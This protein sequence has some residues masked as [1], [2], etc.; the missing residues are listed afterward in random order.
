MI[1]AATWS[2]DISESLA[3]VPRLLGTNGARSSERVHRVTEPAVFRQLVA[4]FG[5]HLRQE[6]ASVDLQSLY[7]VGWHW[8]S[9]SLV[10]ASRGATLFCLS[11]RRRQA[12]C[13]FHRGLAI[14]RPGLGVEMVNVGLVGDVYAGPVA[15]RAESACSPSFLYG[16]QRC[17]CYAQWECVQELAAHFNPVSPPP[18]R[19]GTAF[20]RWVQGQTTV[21][22]DRV[23]FATPGPLGFVLMHLD[24]QNGMGSGYTPG[25]FAEDLYSCASMRHRGEYSCEQVAGTSMAGAFTAIGLE[26]DPRRLGDGIGYQTA[27]I[28][29]DFLGINQELVFLGNNRLK[30]EHELAAP[31]TIH[32]MPLIGT[33][34]VAGAE[35]AEARRHEFAHDDI[36]PLVSFEEDYAR[37]VSDLGRWQ[38][39]N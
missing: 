3:D 26:P 10:I 19:D 16:S 30:W 21:D 9:S 32:R 37:L 18:H 8:A 22:D 1:D 38:R 29:C 27:F 15:L 14:Y 24:C 6:Q 2:G 34:N 4:E 28:A 7:S 5:P 17:N 20:E 33:V 36:G 25:V 12:Y 39:S 13:V 35:E 11:P 23:R 31:Y